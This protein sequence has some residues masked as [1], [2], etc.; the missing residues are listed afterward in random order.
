MQE[1]DSSILQ[2]PVSLLSVW[3]SQ[4][5]A[6]SLFLASMYIVPM[7]AVSGLR[8]Q[9]CKTDNLGVIELLSYLLCNPHRTFDLN[10]FNLCLILSFQLQIINTRFRKIA[11]I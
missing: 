1:H 3:I 6:N 11:E 4:E 8:R 7:I 9:I 10:G 5:L 2:R